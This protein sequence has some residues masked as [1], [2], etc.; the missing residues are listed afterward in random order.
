MKKH[1]WLIFAV[2]VIFSTV[3]LLFNDKN[4]YATGQD[5]AGEARN[6]DNRPYESD[7]EDYAVVAEKLIDVPAICQYPELPTGC[8][9]TA[10]AMVLQYYG[11]NITAEDFAAGWLVCDAG[12][13]SINGL[14]YGPDPN[15]VFAGDPFSEYSYGCYAGPIV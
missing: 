6:K 1:V 5:A 15:E 8:E 4:S 7:N 10:A 2:I 14:Q 9:A 3:F 11:I 13:Y 12:F